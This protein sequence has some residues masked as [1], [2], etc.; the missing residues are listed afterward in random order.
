MNR[1]RTRIPRRSCAPSTQIE[2]DALSNSVPEAFRVWLCRSLN[3][4]IWGTCVE[5]EVYRPRQDG[6][7]VFHAHKCRKEVQSSGS[8]TR[9]A[10]C[11]PT[12]TSAGPFSLSST[13][14]CFDLE[15]SPRHEICSS[16]RPPLV[17]PI[18]RG[19]AWQLATFVGREA[20]KKEEFGFVLI[21]VCRS[22]R[23]RKLAE[24]NKYGSPA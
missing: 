4:C 6:E 21:H 10:H 22:T 12:T 11:R 14:S 20:N 15:R 3:V 19:D 16:S 7:P 24:M 9:E 13:G 8:R 17:I 1:Q 23:C 2:P 18:E 5:G